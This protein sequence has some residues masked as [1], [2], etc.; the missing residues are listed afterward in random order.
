MLPLLLQPNGG[1]PTLLFVLV[2]RTAH[3]TSYRREFLFCRSPSSKPAAICRSGYSRNQASHWV[4]YL[5][6]IS[7]YCDVLYRVILHSLP[8]PTAH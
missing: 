5:T 3:E 4:C 2:A 7:D 8:T 1:R 6:L